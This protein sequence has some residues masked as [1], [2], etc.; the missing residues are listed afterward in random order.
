MRTEAGREERPTRFR[1]SRHGPVFEV[2]PG[3]HYA[4]RRANQSGGSLFPLYYAIAKARNLDEFKAAFA[5]GRLVYHNFVYADV[6]G[7]IFY[8]Y[9]GAHPRKDPRFDWER[10]VDGSDPADRVAGDALRRG[11]AAA[12]EPGERLAAERQRQPVPR[13]RGRRQP[14]PGGL[15]ALPRPGG[16]P[17]DS[18]SAHRRRRQRRPGAA[19]RGACWPRSA[20]SPSTA[21][22]PWPPT[23]TS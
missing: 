5:L 1:W 11:D 7:S 8:L 15:P 21:G 12:R 23:T 13:L 3:E 20:G 2:A 17:A 19:S 4:V 14:R 16:R 9:G 6:D 10:P 18:P 22:R